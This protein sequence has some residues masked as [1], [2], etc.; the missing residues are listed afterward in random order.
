MSRPVAAVRPSPR[1]V[2]SRVMPLGVV[3]M[4]D[5]AFPPGEGDEQAD[6]FPPENGCR[7]S[8]VAGWRRECTRK[9]RDKPEVSAPAVSRN[10]PEYRHST[11]VS[12][13]PRSEATRNLLTRGAG[14][15]PSL[16]SG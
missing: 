10:H 5:M 2:S 11:G 9:Q 13:I 6:G 4:V 8:G 16:R 3:V 14:R 12:V 7:G 1:T 15:D